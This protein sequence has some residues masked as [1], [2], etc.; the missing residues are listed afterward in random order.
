MHF[1]LSVSN[2]SVSE[3]YLDPY[4]IATESTMCST[5]ELNP[6]EVWENMIHLMNHTNNYHLEYTDRPQCIYI[7]DEAL[8]QIY[9]YISDNSSLLVDV[10]NLD[11]SFSDCRYNHGYGGMFTAK[12]GN[13]TS[14]VE[15]YINNKP[16]KIDEYSYQVPENFKPQLI[17]IIKPIVKYVLQDNLVNF[18]KKMN[19]VDLVE[20]M[21][22]VL[23]NIPISVYNK[24]RLSEFVFDNTKLVETCSGSDMYQVFEVLD[25]DMWYDELREENAREI[26]EVRKLIQV[27]TRFMEIRNS[28]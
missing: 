26:D 15:F 20:K 6:K 11:M 21:N 17:P 3:R 9:Q 4:N 2:Y 12:C 27:F 13:S 1:I 10:N 24:S 14:P 22:N 16:P 7:P 25:N 28:L 8:F 19:G 18:I 5:I 23:N